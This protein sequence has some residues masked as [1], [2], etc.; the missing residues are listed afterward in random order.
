[1]QESPD[2]LAHL[3]ACEHEPSAAAAQ[4]AD[5]L[6]QARQCAPLPCAA[7]AYPRVCVRTPA[8]KLPAI[9]VITG[10]RDALHSCAHGSHSRMSCPRSGRQGGQREAHAG[11]ALSL[12]ARKQLPVSVL[13]FCARGAQLR[14]LLARQVAT[15]GEEESAQRA[16]LQDLARQEQKASKLEP[17]L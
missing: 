4:A 14:G 11:R 9:F 10:A 15:S 12:T 3:A 7:A 17:S 8:D 2:L 6:Q 13:T 16:Q 5:D 1:M